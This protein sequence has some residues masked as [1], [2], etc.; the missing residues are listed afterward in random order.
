MRLDDAF[1][2]RS[3]YMTKEAVDK[4]IEPYK[5]KHETYLNLSKLK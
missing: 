3:W 2:H 1:T 5:K 4:E